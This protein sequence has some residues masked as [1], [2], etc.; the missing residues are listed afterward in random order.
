MNAFNRYRL[1][2]LAIA[3]GFAV[4]YFTGDDAE[5][6]HIWAGYWLVVALL[7]RLL[8]GWLGMKGLPRWLPEAGAIARDPVRAAS[9]FLVVL[10]LVAMLGASITGLMLIDNV[11]FLGLENTAIAS[12][13]SGPAMTDGMEEDDSLGEVHEFFANGALTLVLAHIGLVWF[14]RRQQAGRMLFLPQKS[15]QAAKNAIR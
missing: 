1:I 12:W 15:R 13:V 3:A 5:N 8:A 14:T 7:F 9:R 6:A 11:R 10:Q 4:A 2:H